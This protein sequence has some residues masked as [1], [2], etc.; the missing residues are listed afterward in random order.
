M[1]RLDKDMSVILNSPEGD[2]RQKWSQYSQL[3]QRYL[4]LKAVDA[5]DSSTKINTVASVDSDAEKKNF[6]SV[7]Q[8]I[9]TVP[10]RYQSKAR[11][12]LE[13][14][15][16]AGDIRWSANEVFIGDNIL[17]NACMSDLINDALRQ[18]KREVP[19]GHEQFAAA[20]RRANI[21]KNLIG[22]PRV[23]KN[24]TSEPPEIARDGSLS[25][26]KKVR[27][28]S[29]SASSFSSSSSQVLSSP[30]VKKKKKK[31]SRKSS[32]SNKDWE[33]DTKT[34]LP[35][36]SSPETAASTS[37]YLFGWKRLNIFK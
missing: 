15:E 4:D 26:F 12:L 9:R 31:N 17:E 30:Q 36:L 16:K 13:A 35:T 22:N 24:I 28:R 11:R 29:Y 14:I 21:S 33:S 3:L 1:S 8:I 25:P 32:S 10:L 27:S 19:V 18:R 7:E 6:N 37:S 23:L 34:Q 20:L 2:E 5:D